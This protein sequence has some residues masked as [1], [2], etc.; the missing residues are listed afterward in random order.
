MINNSSCIVF[1]WWINSIPCLDCINYNYTSQ[2]TNLVSPIDSGVLPF[3]LNYYKINFS[4]QVEMSSVPFIYIVD[5][6]YKMCTNL[7]T[8]I[9]WSNFLLW[10]FWHFIWKSFVNILEKSFD[11]HN[12]QNEISRGFYEVVISWLECNERITNSLN[13][14]TITLYNFIYFG[15]FGFSIFICIKRKPV[16]YST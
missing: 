10:L 8:L 5:S 6:R 12:S 13:K 4:F 3:I 16:F 2:D 7:Q 1:K 14:Y 11:V 15:L 9:N